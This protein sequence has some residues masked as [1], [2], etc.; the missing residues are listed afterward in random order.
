[1]NSSSKMVSGT[2]IK[3]VHCEGCGRPYEYEMRRV[4]I[5]NFSSADVTREEAGRRATQIGNEK[6]KVLLETN[7]DVVPC[8]MCGAITSK[9]KAER[10][11]AFLVSLGALGMGIAILLLNFVLCLLFG[12]ILVVATILGAVCFFIG[13]L[14]FIIKSKEFFFPKRAKI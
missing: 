12:K 10:R 5:G 11:H 8:P 2:V 3:Q 13:L 6:L 7:C 1:M 4:A 14:L 9:M